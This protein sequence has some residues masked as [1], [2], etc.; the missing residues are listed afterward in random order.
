MGAPAGMPSVYGAPRALQNGYGTA[1]L[2]LGIVGLLLFGCILGPLAIVFGAMG[3]SKV[4]KGLATNK[5]AATTGL[6]LGIV[7]LVGWGIWM[8]AAYG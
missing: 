8:L 6:V 2:V 7:G 4:N 5:G 1:A 3:I